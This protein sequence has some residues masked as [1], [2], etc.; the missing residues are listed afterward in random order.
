MS[1]SR[2]LKKK[3]NF[4]YDK[5]ACNFQFLI[6]SYDKIRFEEKNFDFCEKKV[7]S[8]EDYIANQF[9]QDYYN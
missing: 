5:Y 2:Y 9:L 1:H 4:N 3:N 8:S 6:N 7:F